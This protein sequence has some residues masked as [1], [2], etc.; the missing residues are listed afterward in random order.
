[1]DPKD[2][3]PLLE[4][5]HNIP[6]LPS[7]APARPEAARST[8]AKAKDQAQNKAKAKDDPAPPG[9]V[10]ATRRL[11][12]AAALIMGTVGAALPA[13]FLFWL[14]FALLA[15]GAT[16]EALEQTGGLVPTTF[17]GGYALALGLDLAAVLW[18]LARR[19]L[20]RPAPWW[21]LT[22]L[23][24][25]YALV[26]WV[27][28]PIDLAGIL[29]IPDTITAF[30]LLGADAMLRYV[31][32]F[33]LMGVLSWSL[34]SLWR[35]GRAS[36]AVA[37]RATAVAGCL[38]I[39]GITVAAAVLAAGDRGYFDALAADVGALGM[40][41]SA[42]AE[43]ARRS[44]E[45]LATELGPPT[46][47]RYAGAGRDG[48]ASC[49]ERLADARAEGDANDG[50]PVVEAATARLIRGGLGKPEA[51]DVALLAL[52]RVCQE[53]QAR[54]EPGDVVAR[55]HDLLGKEPQ[56]KQKSRA[57]STMT[58][59]QRDALH[60][61]LAALGPADQLVLELRYIDNLSHARVAARLGQSETEVRLRARRGL[62][63][64]AQT[65]QEP[66]GR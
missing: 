61:A 51:E 7:A 24:L 21:P 55:F 60:A 43:G 48:F 35:A 32:P 30:A 33:V 49:A 29:D 41:T 15:T 13:L 19:F 54:G 50:R 28:V 10:T 65:W 52:L 62:D 18:T 23:V 58:L 57:T 44:Y 2:P 34:G 16:A 12:L 11:V 22:G 56:G 1:M 31:L 4:T 59:G 26:I 20:H 17:G 37:G 25:L 64:L 9:N 8:P 66:G 53:E 6:A 5:L 63:R 14:V 46:P 45:G 39:A 38:G 27:L 42:S 47:T 36:P 3:P 40:P